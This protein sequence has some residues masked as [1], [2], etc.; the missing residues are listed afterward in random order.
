[1][2]AGLIPVKAL[3]RAKTR[4]APTFDAGARLEVAR[5]LLDDAI[6]LALTAPFLEWWVVT[7][8][9]E[10]TSAATAYG[11]STAPDPGE[12]LNLALSAGIRATMDAGAESVTII[13][14]DVP[15]A[16][17]GDLEDVSDTGATSDVVLVPSGDDAGTNG[18]Y[19][20]PPDVLE[21]RF[22]QGSMKSHLQVAES[23]GVRCSILA[24]PRLALDIDTVEDVDAFLEW[25]NRFPSRTGEVLERLRGSV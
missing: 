1:M 4:L 8:D 24:L 25:P 18:L 7:D 9:D 17:R 5:A 11:L 16:Y 6:R 22:G 12:G 21:P 15:L 13:P 3:H 23:R 10:V 14:C 2:D 19:L 20:S